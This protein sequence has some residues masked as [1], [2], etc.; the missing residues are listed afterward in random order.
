MSIRFHGNYCGPGWSDGKYQNSVRNGTTQPI[1]EFDKTCQVHDSAFASGRDIRKAN[2][3]FFNQNVGKGVM[4]TAAA[5]AVKASGF[6]QQRLRGFPSAEG[7]S[8][9]TKQRQPNLR[10]A[11][12]NVSRSSAPVANATKLRL[13]KA[14]YQSRGDGSLCIKHKEYIRDFTSH[15]SFTAFGISVNP[16]TPQLLPWGHAIANMYDLYRFK[17]LTIHYVTAVGTSTAGR[18][19]LAFNY[20]ASLT[21]PTT[22]SGLFSVAPNVEDSLWK[23][24]TLNVPCDGTWRY[25]RSGPVANTDIK[26]Y[27]FGN[28]I[29]GSDLAAASADSGELMV[30][31][32][33]ELKRPHQF[34]PISGDLDS[35]GATGTGITV[36]F[37]TSNPLQW[38][39][40]GVN[41]F[42]YVSGTDYIVDFTGTYLLAITFVGTGLNAIMNSMTSATGLSI[43]LL[44][45]HT[46]AG[47]THCMQVYKIIATTGQTFSITQ[48]GKSTTLTAGVCRFAEYR[49]LL[50]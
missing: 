23:D 12:R 36:P 17:K 16:G 29:I 18:I 1:D 25:T 26:T 24:L 30:E 14:S 21:I 34:L 3:S 46:N 4:R 45:N 43:D 39:S 47:Q 15:T 5:I 9:M 37:G 7:K 41:L 38:Q 6:G 22:K 28:L 20:D 10:G 27:D 35:N 49:P 11:R 44:E 50:S 19:T 48:T 2:Q 33:V 42:R 13:P 8:T 40:A 32:E 31:Y